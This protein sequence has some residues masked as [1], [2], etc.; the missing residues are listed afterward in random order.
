MLQVVAALQDAL[1][2]SAPWG[3]AGA[4]E[5]GA[6]ISLAQR[7]VQSTRLNAATHLLAA[8]LAQPFPPP[9]TLPG[10][11]IVIAHIARLLPDLPAGS[12]DG[13][14]DD[15]HSDADGDKP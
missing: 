2:A 15:H 8:L 1:E 14:D 12:E 6:A 11:S 5:P 10:F 4:P 9:L 13:S 3:E 7:P